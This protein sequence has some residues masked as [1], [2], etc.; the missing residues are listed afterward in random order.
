MDLCTEHVHEWQIAR[1]ISCIPGRGDP[2]SFWGGEEARYCTNLLCCGVAILHRGDKKKTV[3]N[4]FSF[5][6]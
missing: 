3:K 4:S 6:F 1:H 5:F 2:E